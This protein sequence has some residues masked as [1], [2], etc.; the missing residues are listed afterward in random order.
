MSNQSYLFY[1][2]NG[3]LIIGGTIAV[4]KSI[5]FPYTTGL[6]YKSYATNN[7]Y[8]SS[9]PNNALSYFT[10]A[11]QTSSGTTTS[12]NYNDASFNTLD[13]Y[14]KSNSIPINFALSFYGFFI[15]KTTGLWRFTFYGDD[16]ISFWIG[17][18]Y[19]NISN[20]LSSVI[21]SNMN[22]SIVSA[23]IQVTPLAFT[24]NNLTITSATY[25]NGTY[26]ASASSTYTS[27]FDVF[28][29]FT[30]STLDLGG[31]VSGYP[32]YTAGTYTFNPPVTTI[33]YNYSTSSNNTLQGEWVQIK[34]PYIAIIT[35]YSLLPRGGTTNNGSFPS[36]WYICGSND[37]STWYLIDTQ[38]IGLTTDY[39]LLQRY[40][41][42]GETT[43]YLY[44]RMV[45]NAIGNFEAANLLQWNISGFPPGNYSYSVNLTGG[46]PYPI[47]LNYGQST[48]NAIC[49]MGITPPSGSLTYNGTPYFFN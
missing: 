3:Q 33:A 18:E 17:S 43:A 48:N 34:L 23:T 11:T 22:F 30:G 13:T 47:L 25:T 20:Y 6:L 26:T 8:N 14:T 1:N 7:S 45:I 35:S 19:Q 41:V 16:V 5:G 42:K 36:K 15:P 31:W 27:D 2:N 32:T 37:G 46:N 49:K 12:I 21:T 24:S 9:F 29:I 38:N 39:T 40:N 4:Y 10:T 44:F 28:K